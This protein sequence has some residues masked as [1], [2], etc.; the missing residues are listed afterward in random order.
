MAGHIATAG[1]IHHNTPEHLLERARLLS[2]RGQIDLDPCSNETSIV[3]AKTEYRLPAQDGLVLPWA[4]FDQGY[5]LTWCNPP[6]G[7]Y[8]THIRDHQAL[9]VKEYQALVE[10]APEEALSYEAHSLR[11]WIVKADSEFWKFKV[12]PAHAETIMILPASIDTA[13]WQ[14]LIFKK[15]VAWLALRGRMKFLGCEQ[16]AP[17][18]TA[19]VYWG[20]GPDKFVE[21]FK[22]LG[23]AYPC[24]GY[25]KL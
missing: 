24:E 13:Q 12:A 19:L 23:K 1:N 21:A 10:K 17:M 20:T 16:S 11:E 25:N 14:D 9:S 6:F 22:N 8:Y 2:P 18:A 15:A 7:R 3:R 4:V 5:S